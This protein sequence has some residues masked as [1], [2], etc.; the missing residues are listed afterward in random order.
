MWD[1]IS[2]KD[3]LLFYPYHAMQPFLD[4]LKQAAADKNVTSIKITIYRLAENSAIAKALCTA[5]ENGKDVTVLMEL[6]ARFDEKNNINWAE[7]LE[8]AGCKVIYGLDGFK[9]H[10]KIC[11]ITKRQRNGFSYVTQIGTG[12]YNE[13]T[14]SLY[15]DFSLMTADK[16]I[17]EDA[18]SF[19][20]NMLINNTRGN[21]EKLLVAP[22]TLK[23]T[24]LRLIDDEIK[25]GDDGLI[26]ILRGQ[27]RR[28]GGNN[29]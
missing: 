19:F 11:L 4:L 15:T 29:A 22:V 18:L 26:I 17:A 24:L 16:A 8:D 12:N 1:Q 3:I 2:K 28:V 25:Q 10:S 9:C 5:A 23:D 21:Y 14:S 27:C 7:S 13:K 6:R 20:E